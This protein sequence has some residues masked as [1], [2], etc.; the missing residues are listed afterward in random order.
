MTYG[1][2][3]VPHRRHM[4]TRAAVCSSTAVRRGQAAAPWP[5]SGAHRDASSLPTMSLLCRASQVTAPTGVQRS[6]ERERAVRELRSFHILT[7]VYLPLQLIVSSSAS[8]RLLDGLQCGVL[9]RW[10]RHPIVIN[11]SMPSLPSH[12]TCRHGRKPLAPA[13]FPGPPSSRPRRRRDGHDCARWSS[14]SAAAR[15]CTG[16][17]GAGR[18]PGGTEYWCT[19]SYEFQVIFEELYQRGAPTSQSTTRTSTRNTPSISRA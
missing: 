11:T 6:R 16:V 17:A 9:L 8:S 7:D 19:Y 2:P 5:A 1:A 12:G 3:E 10:F 18:I 15:L 4:Q 13:P 14:T